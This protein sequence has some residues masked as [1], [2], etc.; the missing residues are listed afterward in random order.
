ME[1]AFK[2][3][4]PAGDSIEIVQDVP[5]AFNLYRLAGAKTVT[6]KAGFGNMLFHHFA[7]DGFDI[8]YS[9]YL[10]THDAK[11]TASGNLATLELHILFQNKLITYWE[12]IGELVLREKQFEMSYMPFICNT[13]EFT[14]DKVYQTFDF[15]FTKEYL[16][17][18]APYYPALST[19]LEKV[20]Q[21][22]PA[23]LFGTQQ[24]LSPEMITLV[25]SILHYNFSGT[26]AS[27]YFE[28]AVMQLLI[29]VLERSLVNVTD[30]GKKFSAYDIENVYEAKEIILA[31]LGKRYSIKE[32]AKKVGINQ[33]KLQHCFKHLFGTTI[34][35]YAQN[36]RLEYSKQLLKDQQYNMQDIAMMVGYFDASNFTVAFKKCFGYTPEWW[37]RNG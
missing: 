26:M 3:I 24:F 25:N 37:R 34:Y 5:E 35:S 19:F 28:S 20:E 32:L 15:H 8:W 14:G 30:A 22:I 12:G 10:I 27:H 13:A 11:V 31:N 1:I 18:F 29:I 21:K 2:V 33:V 9:N 16:Q 6:A 7:G 4:S 23:R 36:V 17:Q